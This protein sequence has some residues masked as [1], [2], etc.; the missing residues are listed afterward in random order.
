MYYSFGGSFKGVGDK[1]DLNNWEQDSTLAANGDGAARTS[2]D[3]QRSAHVMYKTAFL[4]HF[5]TGCLDVN[6]EPTPQ[7][8]PVP[9]FSP[10]P[11]VLQ[12]PIIMAAYDPALKV[13]FCSTPGGACDSGPDLLKG[14]GS[15]YPS[16]LNQPNTLDGC[17]DGGSGVYMTD[18]TVESIKVK[19]LDGGPIGP[20]REMVIEAKVYTWS[21]T[22]DTVDFWYTSDATNP[23]WKLVT[24]IK[25]T[26]NDSFNTI[27]ANFILPHGTLQ[28]V[29]VTNRYSGG[30]QACATSGWDDM[31]DL[32]FAVENSC[33]VFDCFERCENHFGGKIEY[34][35]SK[36]NLCARACAE[37]NGGEVADEFKYC[38][39]DPL[40]RQLFCLDQCT[41]VSRQVERQAYCNFGCEFWEN[42]IS[43]RGIGVSTPTPTKSLSLT[44]THTPTHPPTHLPSSVPTKEPTS[45]PTKTPTKPPT[46]AP[47]V[48]AAP[49]STPSSPA[50]TTGCYIEECFAR[51]TTQYDGILS[52]QSGTAYYCAKGCAAM[53]DGEVI[54]ATKYCSVD[55]VSRQGF[56]NDECQ[57]ASS[58]AYLQNACY[59]GCEFWELPPLAP[60][61]APTSLAPSKVCDVDGC[62][63]RCTAQYGGTIFD[64]GGTAY[65][66]AK[67]CAKMGG[68]ELLDDMKYC[69]IKDPVERQSFCVN[70][71]ENAA[72]QVYRKDACT[73]GCEFW[74]VTAA[75]SSAP[76][77]LCPQKVNECFNYCNSILSGKVTWAG[78]KANYCSEGCA[79]M[80]GS[81]VVDIYKY[82]SMTNAVE[83]RVFCQDECQHV[84]HRTDQQDYCKLGC[85]FWG[86]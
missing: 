37:M 17:P 58:Q 5:H 40:E 86:I 50:P 78:T 48:T 15:M 33:P 41:T 39:I 51:C 20:G 73:Y 42:L 74:D 32:A 18:E 49:S 29:R 85:D 2:Q 30:G 59:F 10:K 27:S 4:K 11:T 72:T 57:Y 7:P 63:A 60:S 14:H 8:V 1:L 31:D 80:N 81:E 43:V 66:C 84:S 54:D 13:P 83:R 76:S 9:T 26:E 36:T 21:S 35:Y 53:G 52:D 65:Y 22:T 19:S 82:C 79:E 25:P 44:P 24:S 34:E 77:S 56:C 47:T 68:G 12:A 28:A 67:G 69:S 46:E 55:P 16:E 61:P 3:P 70:E 75:P 45:N 23:N 38:L 64:T 62:F 6:F 71:C